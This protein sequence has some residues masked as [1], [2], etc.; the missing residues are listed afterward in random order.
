MPMQLL[1]KHTA[2][3]NVECNQCHHVHTVNVKLED[4]ERYLNKGDLVQNVWPT[5]DTWDREVIIGYRT[6]FYQCKRCFE[7]E[8]M[9]LTRIDQETGE[10]Q[11]LSFQ[12]M[13]DQI[14]GDQNDD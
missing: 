8:E 9:Q 5:Y 3:L 12:E 14:K 1:D 7:K 10:V 13:M 4:L 11:R 6:G 2:V